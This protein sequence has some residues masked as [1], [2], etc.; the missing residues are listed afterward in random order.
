MTGPAPLMRGVA[1]GLARAVCVFVH[2]RGQ[3]PEEMDAHVLARVEAPHVAFVLP[4]AD[5]GAWYGARAVDRLTDTTRAEMA[6]ALDRI[7]RDLAAARAAAPGVPVV[8][9]GF[10]QGACLTLEYLCREGAAVDAACAFTGCRV[11]QA[12]DARPRAD[13]AGLPVL[14]TGSDADPWIPVAAWASASAEL[15]SM[16]ARLRVEVLPGRPHEVSDFELSVF[17]QILQRVCSGADPM[18]EAA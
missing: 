1:P 5:G 8:L 13:L 17:S 3:S 2:G 11:G 14:L 7:G 10:S 6:D 15:G 16:G 18:A 4:R 9:A 12:G